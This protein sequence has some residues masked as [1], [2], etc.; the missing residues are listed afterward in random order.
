M[1]VSNPEVWMEF[2]CREHDKT[3]GARESQG[4]Q[5][6]PHRQMDAGVEQTWL[7]ACTPVSWEVIKVFSD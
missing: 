2:W 3:G 7:K 6:C 1:K 4:L 5:I